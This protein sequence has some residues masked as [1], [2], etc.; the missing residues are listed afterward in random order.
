MNNFLH[1]LQTFHDWLFEDIVINR[2]VTIKSSSATGRWIV[3]NANRQIIKFCHSK[4]EAQDWA[5]S[6]GYRITGQNE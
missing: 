3:V 4:S 6:H 2:E 1:L 5:T